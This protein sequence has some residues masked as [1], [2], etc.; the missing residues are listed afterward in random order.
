MTHK[1]ELMHLANKPMF[2]GYIPK[3]SITLHI[4]INNNKN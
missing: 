2:I 1:G 4:K 3:I